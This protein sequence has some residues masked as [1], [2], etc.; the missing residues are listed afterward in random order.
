M[1]VSNNTE[2]EEVFFEELKLPPGWQ[3][4]TTQGIPFKLKAKEQEVRII[5]FSVP[6]TYP[7]GSYQV[8]YSVRSQRDYGITDSDA[9]SVVVLPVLK[10]QM[11][12][13][14]KPE[15]VIAGEIYEARVQLINRGNSKI[16]IKIEPKAVPD[17]PIKVEPSEITLEVGKAQMLRIEVKTDEKLKEKITHILKIKAQGEEV[18]NGTISAEQSFSVVIIPRVTGEFDPYHRLNAQVRLT[19]VSEN[20]KSGFQ[21]EFTGSG[22]LD[23]EGKRRV[24]FLFRGPD[25]QDKSRFGERDEYRFSYYDNLLDFHLGDR[26]YS[27]SPLTV[28]YKYGRGSEVNIHPGKLGVGAFY[29]KTRWEEPEERELGTYV[30]YKF[31]NTFSIKG[32][33]LIK[34]RDSS[35]SSVDYHDKIYSIQAKINPNEKMDLDLEYSFN[36]SER[37]KKYSD[38][39]YRVGLRGQFPNQLWYSL[40]KIHA[41]S[42]YFGYYN[43]TDY[44]TGTITIPIYQKLRGNFSYRSLKDNLDLDPAK[45]TANRETSYRAGVSYPFSS[46]TNISLDYED[47]HREDRLLPIDYNFDEKVLILGLGQSFQRVS[48]QALIERGE[49]ENRLLGKTYSLERYSLYAYFRPSEWQTYSFYTRIGHERYT[50]SLERTKSA[51]ASATWNIINNLIININ[52]NKNNFSSEKGQE[53]DNLLSTISYILPNKHFLTFRSYWSKSKGSKEESSFVLSYTIPFKIPVSKKKSIGMLKGRVY[54]GEKEGRP[55]IPN[56]ILTAGDAT[57]VT[58]KKGGFIF[59]SLKPGTYFLKIEKGSIGLHRV[60]T[61]KLPVM[62]EIKGGETTQVEIAAVTSCRISGRV[63]IFTSNNNGKNNVHINGN[64][65]ENINNNDKNNLKEIGG[66]SNILVEITNGK[67]KLRELTDEK[68]RFS[69]EEMRPGKWTVKVYDENLPVH[70]YLET[71]EFSVEL[72]PGE[73]KEII[74]RVLPR[75]RPIQIIEEGEVKQE[76]GKKTDH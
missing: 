40:E 36:D 63:V 41:G 28:Q 37:E 4:I 15:A 17:F 31:N 8:T 62:V 10:L 73:E 34:N 53:Q 72:T 48:F 26:S 68:G 66:L 69:F 47:F 16:R 76:R 64:G 24:V 60:T 9:F 61:E 20:G 29:L 57:A 74:F 65:K 18:K 25:I 23:E 7:A 12:V 3:V 43:D 50:V 39:A 52:Y 51:G 27:L 11:I 2:R 22:S 21:A 70:H 42:K 55:P 71:E 14:D 49:L 44:T 67:E 19:G 33:F 32:N 58:D 35:S 13:E 59:P 45:S 56:V 75:I 30:K 46:R 5:A 1:L 6:I 54:D 38:N